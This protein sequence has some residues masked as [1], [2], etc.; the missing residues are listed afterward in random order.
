[1]EN[2]PKIYKYE[3]DIS[4]FFMSSSFVQSLSASNTIMVST[5]EPLELADDN[6][7]P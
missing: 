1:M 6:E 5:P 2:I 4:E 3:T 7:G